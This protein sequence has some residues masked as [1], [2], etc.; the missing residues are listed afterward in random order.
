MMR[1][2]EKPTAS[3]GVSGLG[4]YLTLATLLL[5]PGVGLLILSLTGVPWAFAC[6]VGWVAAGALG[7]SSWWTASRA[8]RGGDIKFMKY[9][10]GGVL[11]RMLF[12]AV[13][14]VVV[15]GV[16]LLQPTPFVIGML[17]GMVVFMGVEVAGLLSWAKRSS[18]EAT[19]PLQ[20]G[21]P[22]EVTSRG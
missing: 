9:L 22:G 11:A 12:C 19:R 4:T 7:L 5:V 3:A 20:A 15:V 13:I 1:R 8:L 2:S 17:G 21:S 16:E 6:L 18:M 10:V 14:T